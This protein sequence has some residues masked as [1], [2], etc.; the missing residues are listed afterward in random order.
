MFAQKV[1]T[2][3]WTCLKKVT[4]DKSWGI[5]DILAS[6]AMFFRFPSQVDIRLSIFTVCWEETEK[7][8]VYFLFNSC[9]VAAHLV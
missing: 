1:L 4:F 7:N 9:G 2:N 8:Q 5:R 3:K 6:Y